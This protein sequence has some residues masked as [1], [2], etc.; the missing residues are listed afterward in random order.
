M[1]AGT[2]EECR[3][4]SP[5]STQFI[6]FFLSPFT[7]DVQEL[8]SQEVGAIFFDQTAGI[9]RRKNYVSA[10][11]T[12]AHSMCVCLWHAERQKKLLYKIKLSNKEN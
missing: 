3:K 2:L 1:R 6:F 8:S 5:F 9:R 7:L 4:L 11:L 12:S 10:L